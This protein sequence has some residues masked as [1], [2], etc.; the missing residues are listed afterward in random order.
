[1]QFHPVDADN[2]AR[3]LQ[4]AMQKPPERLADIAVDCQ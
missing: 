2:F 1:V 3:P 4:L